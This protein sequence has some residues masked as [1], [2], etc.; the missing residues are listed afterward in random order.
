MPSR[1]CKL[2]AVTQINFRTILGL[3]ASLI[4]NWSSQYTKKRTNLNGKKLIHSFKN[5]LMKFEILPKNISIS[6]LLFLHWLKNIGQING[7]KIIE[8][9]WM[10]LRNLIDYQNYLWNKTQSIENVFFIFMQV[11]F[12]QDM[13]NGWHSKNKVWVFVYL[14]GTLMFYCSGEACWIRQCVP[15]VYRSV[16]TNK[17]YKNWQQDM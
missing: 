13:R 17:V 11:N 14:Y 5:E 4:S 6:R 8:N 12:F 7:G 15:Y 9:L 3:F 2:Q 10:N 16:Q 1:T